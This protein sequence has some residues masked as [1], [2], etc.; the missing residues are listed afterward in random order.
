M[1]C[2]DGGVAQP[3]EGLSFAMGVW[4]V[5]PFS[6]DAGLQG[7]LFCKI[8]IQGGDPEMELY[9]ETHMWIILRR[10]TQW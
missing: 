4:P 9:A 1:G 7:D 10:H 6:C 2:A 5:V 3:G 8:W